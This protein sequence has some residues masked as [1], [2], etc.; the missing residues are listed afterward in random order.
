[1]SAGD[2]AS[3]DP[4]KAYTQATEHWAQALDEMMN[5]SAGT[6]ASEALL[7]LW[8]TQQDARASMVERWAEAM[9]DLVGTEGFAAASSQILIQ[10]A[11]QQQA[12]REASQAVA[13]SL[14]VPTTKDLAAVAQLVVNVER[15]VDEATDQLA[16]L[17]ANPDPS[18]QLAAIAARLVAIERHLDDRARTAVD[19]PAPSQAP[20]AATRTTRP[21]AGRSRAPK[22][23]S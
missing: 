21:R 6:E 10:Y 14:S 15:K 3:G 11:Q 12:L 8:A 22:T 7:K 18:A 1:M 23:T 16:L 13:E 20:A 19:A 5:A 4:R 9:E 2:G 17:V